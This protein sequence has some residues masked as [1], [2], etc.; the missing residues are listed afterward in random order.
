M[1]EKRKVRGILGIIEAELDGLE[2][3]LE[4]S[5]VPGLGLGATEDARRWAEIGRNIEALAP[6]SY[7]EPKAV[8]RGRGQPKKSPL[9]T[10]D[11]LRAFVLYVAARRIR[12][13]RG[14]SQNE[15]LEISLPRL[16]DEAVKMFPDDLTFRRSLATNKL[17]QSVKRGRTVQGI[18]EAWRSPRLEAELSGS[19]FNQD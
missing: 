8:K 14:M 13:A 16:I 19:P 3:E 7:E 11:S 1:R 10:N 12:A 6:L 17:Y 5:T 9:A 15:P 2:W 18:D 4:P